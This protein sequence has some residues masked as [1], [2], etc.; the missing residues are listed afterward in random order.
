MTRSSLRRSEK[1]YR[2]GLWLIAL[3]FAYFLLGLGNL[4]IDDLPKVEKRLKI[5][6]FMAQPQTDEA[7]AALET[8]QS[9]QKQAREA[10]QQARLDLKETQADT[11]LA[12]EQYNTWL[13]TKGGP[14]AGVTDLEAG[15]RAAALDNLRAIERLALAKV[16]SAQR[17]SVDANTERKRAQE[18]LSDLRETAKESY[19]DARN[20]QTLRVFGYRLA[21]VLPLVIAGFY[22]YRKYRQGKYWPFAWGFIIFSGVTF[23]VE[24]GPYLP[25]FGGYVYQPLALVLVVVV[26]R[27]AITGLNQYLEKQRALEA[28][29]ESERR[30]TLSHD[31][32]LA[33]LAKG[34]CPGCERAAELNNEKVDYCSHCGLGLFN[35]CTSCSSRKSTFAKYC[36]SCG[37]ESLQSP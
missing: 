29:P 21:L 22:V 23:L 20:M 31:M 34:V 4:V 10:E 5:D 19:D 25:A 6:D 13:T 33:R 14:A 15:S 32:A 1:L 26:G 16:Q 28:Q 9:K 8:A 3:L 30:K 17:E 2:I 24:L 35:K 36:Q 37:T 18:K 12:E 27:K 7:K 11:L